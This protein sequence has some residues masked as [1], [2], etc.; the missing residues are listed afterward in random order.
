MQDAVPSQHAKDFLPSSSISPL[1]ILPR[2]SN[3]FR[4]SGETSVFH[5]TNGDLTRAFAQD[6]ERVNGFDERLKIMEDADLCIRLHETP[7]GAHSRRRIHMVNR[8]AE[9]SG[10]R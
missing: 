7:H 5:T 10:R 9:T 6:F 3:S 2:T 8:V 4:G 1:L